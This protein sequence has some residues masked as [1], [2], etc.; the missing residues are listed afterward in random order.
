MRST[1]RRINFLP[2]GNGGA[3]VTAFGSASI[4]KVVFAA[5]ELLHLLQ[6]RQYHAIITQKPVAERP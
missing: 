4:S 6:P 3:Q 1:E 5:A 2:G